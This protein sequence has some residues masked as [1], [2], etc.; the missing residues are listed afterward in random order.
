MSMIKKFN[1]HITESLRDKM[2]PKSDNDI[3]VGIN[4][5]FQKIQDRLIEMGL[6][7]VN[8]KKILTNDKDEIINYLQ[9]GK[10]AYY[11]AD[12]IKWK[13]NGT[14][15]FESLRDQMTPKKDDEI[16]KNLE[17]SPPYKALSIAKHYKLNNLI[18]DIV[19]RTIPVNEQLY[20]DIKEYKKENLEDFIE[21]MGEWMEYQ[22]HDSNILNSTFNILV[23]I[24]IGHY[25]EEEDDDGEWEEDENDEENPRYDMYSDKTVEA[26]KQ[27]V[28]QFAIDEVSNDPSVNNG[29]DDTDEGYDDT[30]DY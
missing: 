6:D 19:K 10:R 20:N 18:D 22:G 24:I 9:R 12:L 14:H 21:F 2:T 23:E 4:N 8:I 3:N 30:D 25:D 17:S 26:F 16:S 7:R 27:L 1:E 11:I 28:V 13:Y 29:N 15:T 5:S